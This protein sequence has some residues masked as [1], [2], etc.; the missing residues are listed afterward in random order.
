M[1]HAVIMKQYWPR[2]QTGGKIRDIYISEYVVDKMI[3]KYERSVERDKS[4]R[5]VKLP[6]S[7]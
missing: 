2:K 7:L 4:K 1:A 5:R 3:L 6:F